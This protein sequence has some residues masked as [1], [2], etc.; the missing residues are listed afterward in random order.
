MNAL[1]QYKL[2]VFCT[3]N[4]IIFLIF[5]FKFNNKYFINNR[6]YSNTYIK[7]YL[8]SNIVFFCR[9]KHTAKCRTQRNSTTRT[10]AQIIIGIK[11]NLSLNKKNEV[12]L[13]YLFQVSTFLL[14]LSYIVPCPFHLKWYRYFIIFDSLFTFTN[15]T[16]SA[17]PKLLFSLFS[18]G[19]CD[20]FKQ[21]L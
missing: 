1:K 20:Y 12:L 16:L 18:K 15:F 11:F 3:T 13:F 19:F 4:I 2:F 9:Y 6:F 5:Y 21:F 8:D 17:K 14:R 7:L 10:I